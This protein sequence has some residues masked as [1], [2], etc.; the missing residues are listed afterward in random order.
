M[1][2]RQQ[3]KWDPTQSPTFWINHASRGIMRRFEERLRPLG[4]GMA[5]L[6]VAMA[7]REHGP[8]QQKALLEHAA[9]EQPTMTALLKRMERDGLIK[10]TP[11]PDDARAHLV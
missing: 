5:Y 11:D 1:K 6:R 9:I 2:K 10:R 4:F 8:L 3:Q 7:L